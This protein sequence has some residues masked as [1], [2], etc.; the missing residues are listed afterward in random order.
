M[1]EWNRITGDPL[2]PPADNPNARYCPTV[3]EVDQLIDRRLGTNGV[4]KG[5]LINF[6]TSKQAR[7]TTR[8]NAHGAQRLT[9]FL[10]FL[11]ALDLKKIRLDYV[12]GGTLHINK[13]PHATPFDG[14]PDGVIN[15]IRNM[16][17]HSVHGE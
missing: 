3:E 5:Q 2:T 11:R 8:F 10:S 17:N 12:V 15:Q 13:L 14:E 1:W 9:E 4:L 6:M 16:R 7:W